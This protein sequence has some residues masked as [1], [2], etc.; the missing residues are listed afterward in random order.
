MYALQLNISLL[1]LVNLFSFSSIYAFSTSSSPRISSLAYHPKDKDLSIQS[2]QN[3]EN[4]FMREQMAFARR[5]RFECL[6]K[7]DRTFCRNREFSS[8]GRVLFSTG[9]KE[10]MTEG[11]TETTEVKEIDEPLENGIPKIAENVDNDDFL[12]KRD[13]LYSLH[14]REEDYLKISAKNLKRFYN[15]FTWEGHSINY[16]VAG[17][18]NGKNILLVHG[19]GANVNHFRFQFA[20]LPKLGYRVYALDLLGFG[21]SDKP[22]S[23]QQFSLELWRNLIYDFL[24]YVKKRDFGEG[25]E[26]NAADNNA[27]QFTVCGNSIGGLLSL[28]MAAY[29]PELVNGVVCFN[30]AGG[31]VSFRDSELPFLLR[32]I[33]WIFKT[34]LFQEDLLGKYLFT[35]FKTKENVENIL[36]QVYPIDQ[37]NVDEDLLNML[38]EPS[39]DEGALQVFLKVM[40]GDAGESPEEVLPKISTPNICLIWGAQ[41]PWTPVSTG[42]HPGDKFSLYNQNV[43]LNVIDSGH[44]P[45]DET[46]EAV[47]QILLPY[48]EKIHS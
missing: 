39:E 5:Y 23:I 35:N 42:L 9:P 22:I 7:V 37:T 31:M 6:L 26:E 15:K 41:D 17:P 3:I 11:S 30:A 48:L 21:G 18:K 20:T 19:F 47:H 12:V 34:V 43:Q 45:M 33:W 40:G 28:H 14:E 27:T 13:Y 38:L 29:H 32:P 24:L 25:E 46:P 10:E 2:P 44:C 8:G 36:K 1:L 4:E 16:R